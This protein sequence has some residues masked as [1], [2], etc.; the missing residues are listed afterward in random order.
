MSHSS[1]IRW[2]DAA[3]VVTTQAAQTLR[4]LLDSEEVYLDLLEAYTYA[5]GSDQDF[6]ELLFQDELVLSGSPETLVATQEQIDKVTD[7]RLAIQALH[8]LYQALNGVA[9]TQNDRSA[10]LR[11]MS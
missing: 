7:L 3:Q 6:A 5:G 9:V 2:E 1:Q 11:R 4:A 10:A 8:E